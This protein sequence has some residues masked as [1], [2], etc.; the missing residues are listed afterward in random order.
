MTYTRP[1]SSTAILT[2]SKKENGRYI[3]YFD[4]L[5]CSRHYCA[6]F[7]LC[8]SYPWLITIL[9]QGRNH[10]SAFYKWENWR[11]DRIDGLPKALQLVNNGAD[12]EPTQVWPQSTLAAPWL[13][14]GC[15]RVKRGAALTLTSCV[16]WTHPLLT[17]V[18]G[19]SS[20]S[21]M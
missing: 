2:W 7:F 9:L 14:P 1:Y 20:L 8:Q 19:F 6:F 21:G 17:W 16:A 11:P 12:S 13:H 10:L 15:S 5:L 3:M 18:P 4:H